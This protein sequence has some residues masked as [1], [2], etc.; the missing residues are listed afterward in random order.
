MYTA[1]QMS[2]IP[3]SCFELPEDSI[4][5]D[6]S[7][8][9]TR[10]AEPLEVLHT[11]YHVSL[12]DW[13]KAWQTVGLGKCPLKGQMANAIFFYPLIFSPKKDRTATA[14]L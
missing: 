8:E 5:Q 1:L 6:G 9:E 14:L 2:G 4:A 7:H 11:A 10:Y 3:V 12:Y 13:K